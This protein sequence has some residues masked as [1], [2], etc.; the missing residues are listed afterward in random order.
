MSTSAVRGG[1]SHSAYPIPNLWVRGLGGWHEHGEC[2]RVP[3]TGREMEGGKGN[4][5]P[6]GTGPM[7]ASFLER[8]RESCRLAG[9]EPK[10]WQ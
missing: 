8:G 5:R 1:P 7:R 4:T 3:A 2:A 10:V 6:P 9:R